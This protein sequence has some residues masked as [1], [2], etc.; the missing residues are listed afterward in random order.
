MVQQ[1][2]KTNINC[3]NCVKAVS[4]FINDVAG[5]SSWEVDTGH[6]DKLLTISGNV[7]LEEVIEAIE[8]AG[9]DVELNA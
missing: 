5:I 8:E 9:F 6:P 2:F 1:S 3:S 7:V 4:N